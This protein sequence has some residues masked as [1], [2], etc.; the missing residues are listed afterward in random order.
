VRGSLSCSQEASDRPRSAAP[1]GCL[2]GQAG[3][4]YDGVRHVTG[5][6]H[7]GSVSFVEQLFPPPGAFRRRRRD[8]AGRQ[9]C[10]PSVGVRRG[11]GKGEWRR[12]ASSGRGRGGPGLEAVLCIGLRSGLRIAAVSLEWREP[13]TIA[14]LMPLGLRC[15]ASLYRDVDMLGPLLDA[16]E[17]GHMLLDLPAGPLPLS[18]VAC[19]SAATDCLVDK[20]DAEILR[21]AGHHRTDADV[22][23]S[24]GWSH[25]SVKRRMERLIARH[26]QLNRYGLGAWAAY[27]GFARAEPLDPGAGRTG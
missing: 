11:E 24:V 5:V 15:Y 6:E 26:G 4:R 27:K 17:A 18:G 22:A 21:V 8:R 10:R 2:D 13:P 19:P 23:D 20:V 3:T 14:S 16:V 9:L 25:G 1:E 12:S 7:D